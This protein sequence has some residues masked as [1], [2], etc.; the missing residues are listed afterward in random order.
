MKQVCSGPVE[1]RHKIIGHY[2][3]AEL[4]QIS[5]RGLI[6]FNIFVSGRKSHFDIIMYI[7][8]FYHI[9]M[10]SVAFNLFSHLFDFGHFPDLAWLLVMKRPYQSRHSRDLADHILSDIV[11]S[12]S[13]PAKCHLHKLFPPF[14]VLM[15]L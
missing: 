14:S 11:I 12:F 3:N 4:R 6:I 13:I 10:E 9:H 1:N 5:Q 7:H 8:T 15:M 2:F